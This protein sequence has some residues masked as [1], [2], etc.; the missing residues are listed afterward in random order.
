[1]SE[2]A[3]TS[4]PPKVIHA[5]LFKMG[6]RSMAEAYKILG[7]HT[8]HGM[9][10]I[11]GNPWE[12]LEKAAEAKWPAFA[13]PNAGPAAAASTPKPF[14][15][16]Q[17]DELWSSYDAITDLGSPFA[18]DLVQAYPD[19]KVVVVQ[20][21]FDTWWPSVRS[22]VLDAIFGRSLDLILLVT[23][24]PPVTSTRKQMLGFF[25]SQSPGEIDERKAREA[26]ER[27][28]RRVRELVPAER[29]LEYTMGSGWEPLCAFLGKE[30]PDVP[31]P[32]VNEG[33]EFRKTGE[34]EYRVTLMKG[35]AAIKP[36]V[37]TA[38]SI[39]VV[40]VAIKYRA[41]IP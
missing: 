24:I 4:G 12:Q 39:G 19:A 20:R 26:Y 30:V 11:W 6:T 7:Y 2:T 23:K 33:E 40:A 36:W 5:A 27:H 10:D 34:K 35:W 21:N 37:F 38:L 18:D 25:E 22:G 3:P 1:M 31:F 8:H 16:E 14:T 32:W 41:N 17:W 9:D 29:R 28:F 13:G 15:R